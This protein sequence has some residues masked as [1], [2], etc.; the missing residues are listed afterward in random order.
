MEKRVCFFVLS[1]RK[2]L[3]I[4]LPFSLPLSLSSLFPFSLYPTFTQQKSALITKLDPSI[5]TNKRLPMHLYNSDLQSKYCFF[6]TR[7][8]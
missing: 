1:R 3:S 5:I 7:R 2:F 6:S 8:N 4:S